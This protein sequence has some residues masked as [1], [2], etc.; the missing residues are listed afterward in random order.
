MPPPFRALHPPPLLGRASQHRP[1]RALNATSHSLRVPRTSPARTQPTRGLRTHGAHGRPRA[2]TLAAATRARTRR[3]PRP[4][5]P[6]P[7][8]V[9]RVRV[10][11][12]TCTCPS[13]AAGQRLR[14]RRRAGPQSGRL[15]PRQVVSLAF[16]KPADR[17]G[18]SGGSCVKLGLKLTAIVLGLCSRPFHYI[19]IRCLTPRRTMFAALRHLVDEYAGSRDGVD[20][21]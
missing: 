1:A 15:Q 21:G 9:W 12:P 8:G 18:N 2:N 16:L 14:R 5:P 7:T 17:A 6:L 3:G 10:H 4:R 20:R 19:L 13:Q 11:A